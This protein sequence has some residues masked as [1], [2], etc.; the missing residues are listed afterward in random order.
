METLSEKV[1]HG[2]E[3]I[4]YLVFNGPV[5]LRRGCSS[6]KCHLHLYRDFLVVTNSRCKINFKIKYIIPLSALWMGECVV[7]DFVGPSRARKS[8]LLGWPMENFVATFRS[9]AKKREWWTVLQRSIDEHKQKDSGKSITLEILTEDI[10][11][12]NTS[13]TVTAARLDTV[14]DIIKKLRPLLGIPNAEEDYQLW[15]S[16]SQEETPSPLLGHENPYAIRMCDLRNSTYVAVGPRDY[17]DYL[18]INKA[19]RELQSPHKPGLFILKPK[20]SPKDQSHSEKTVRRR[21]SLINW[22]FR[23]GPDYVRLD[24]PGPNTGRFGRTLMDTGEDG[25]LSATVL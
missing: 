23:R 3:N 10:P 14:N 2:E 20:D 15:F 7:T 8:I 13:F 19:I 22:I 1:A 4:Q 24:T 17:T 18:D 6:R 25:E 12:W 9:S 11:S 5:E 21:C 16:S